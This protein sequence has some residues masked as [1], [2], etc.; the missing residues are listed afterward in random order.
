M[1][2]KYE[3]LIYEE[4]GKIAII[5]LN[6]PDVRNAL[7]YPL[8][9]DLDDAVRGCSA[10]AMVITG[11]GTAF[12]AGGDMKQL[13]EMSYLWKHHGTGVLTEP[14]EEIC[15]RTLRT[16]R[17]TSS[18]D[19]LLY[20]NIPIIAAVNG[21]AAGQGLE[22]ALTAD[23]RVAS[24]KA[25]FCAAFVK[26]GYIGDAAVF[27]R[28]SQLVGREHT[29]ELLMTGDTIDA[30]RALEIGLVSRVVK[31]DEVVEAATGIANKIASNP[32]LAVQAYKEGLRNTLD[33]NWRAMGSWLDAQWV[34]EEG[35]EDYKEGVRAFIEKRIPNYTGR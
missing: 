1:K 33:P 31:H 4:K 35:T 32:P 2:I 23:I 34:F 16:N 21:P 25:T 24:E 5:T 27:G 13:K 28:L 11:A 18:M 22:I 30:H 17:L 3:T 8:F 14:E 29:A 20:T 12:C 9:L 7:N 19:A 10:K 26:R 6:R 15:R